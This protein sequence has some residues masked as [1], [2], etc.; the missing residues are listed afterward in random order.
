[1]IDP[2]MKTASFGSGRGFVM[3]RL[4]LLAP[5]R[6]RGEMDQLTQTLFV[7]EPGPVIGGGM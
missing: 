3:I 4:S 2:S 1:M 5:L 7:N 6:T